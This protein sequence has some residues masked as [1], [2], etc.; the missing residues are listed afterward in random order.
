VRAARGGSGKDPEELGFVGRE[1]ELI[2]SLI[3]VVAVRPLISE[4]RIETNVMAVRFYFG[5]ASR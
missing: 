4:D 3:V 5:T 2:G 1:G